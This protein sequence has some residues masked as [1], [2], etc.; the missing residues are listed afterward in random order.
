MHMGGM[1]Q[2]YIEELNEVSTGR[3]RR[4]QQQQQF[5]KNEICDHNNLMERCLSLGWNEMDEGGTK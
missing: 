2:N 3:R 5:F 1:K 4:Q